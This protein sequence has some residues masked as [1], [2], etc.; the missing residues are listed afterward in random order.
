MKECF[1]LWTFQVFSFS[2]K[3]SNGRPIYKFHDQ[4]LICLVLHKRSSSISLRR[5]RIVTDAIYKENKLPMFAHQKVDTKY[6]PAMLKCCYFNGA[7]CF[8]HIY[9]HKLNPYLKSNSYIRYIV[10]STVILSIGH[11][12]LC[13]IS[14]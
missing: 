13:S 3:I 14:S 1:K 6:S 12:L 10:L 9:A 11:F 5:D 7:P 2:F 8:E 4:M